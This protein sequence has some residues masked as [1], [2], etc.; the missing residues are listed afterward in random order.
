M[1]QVGMNTNVHHQGKTLHIQTEDSG[2][3]HGHIITHLFLAGTI[4]ATK[5]LE[6]DSNIAS[7]QLQK[8]LK[9]QHQ[10]MI[11]DLQAGQYDKKI[12]LARPR[13]AQGTIPLARQSKK[14]KSSDSKIISESRVS[15]QT[16]MS[17]STQ[18]NDGL[19]KQPTANVG[20]KMK[21][22]GPWALPRRKESLMAQQRTHDDE[23]ST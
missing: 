23:E 3:H 8:L 1:M 4:I 20:G 2:S 16:S 10:E 5:K 17:D 18:P 14:N 21:I 15:D 11:N 7:E 13:R 19:D 9:T 22:G 6:Y 12:I